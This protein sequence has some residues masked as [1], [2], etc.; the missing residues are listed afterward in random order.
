MDISEPCGEH[1]LPAAAHGARD[2]ARGILRCGYRDRRVHHEKR[3]DAPIGEHGR[4]RGGEALGRRVADDVD[5]VAV[6]PLCRKVF[7]E[8]RERRLREGGQGH[9]V[10]G[11]AVGGDHARAAAVGDDREPFAFRAPLAREHARGREQLRIGLDSHRAGAAQ[12]A[13]EHRIAADQRAGMAGRG[14]R[15]A[16]MAPDLERDHRLH[17]RRRAQRRDIAARVADAFDI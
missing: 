10:L 1:G 17:A 11:G 6:R 5:R 16:R 9:P 12:R 8:D 3:V 4:A 14:A 13:I 15:A 2:R 7:I